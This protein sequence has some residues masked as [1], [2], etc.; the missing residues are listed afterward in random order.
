MSNRQRIVFV[1]VACIVL[2]LVGA[3]INYVREQTRRK[4]LTA[5][6]AATIEN[7]DVQRAFNPDLGKE[8]TAGVIVTFGFE[9]N[10]NQYKRKTW[11]AVD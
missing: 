4:R 11:I 5:E 1:L 7:V 2:A 9:L 8:Y 3:F 10:G 6:V